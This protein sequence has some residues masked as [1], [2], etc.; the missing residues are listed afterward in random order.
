VLSKTSNKKCKTRC[1]CGVVKDI[2]RNSL[3]SGNTK[4][5]GCFR[6]ER[7]STLTFNPSL[8]E[9]DRISRMLV[10]RWTE[11]R[12]KI[13]KRDKYTCLICGTRTPPLHVHHLKSWTKFKKLRFAFDNLVTL[14]AYCH[15]EVHTIKRIALAV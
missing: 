13:R 7:A 10:P 9:K 1:D 6:R 4:S 14:C 11:V 12:Q 15:K 3:V 2:D 8:T 5:C